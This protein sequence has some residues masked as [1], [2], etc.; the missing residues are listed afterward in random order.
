[1]FSV[2]GLYKQIIFSQKS[3]LE[4]LLRQYIWHPHPKNTPPYYFYYMVYQLEKPHLIFTHKIA[5]NYLQ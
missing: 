4:K 5:E 2:K 3:G 1:M